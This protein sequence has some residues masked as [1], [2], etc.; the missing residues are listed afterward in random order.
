MA[1]KVRIKNIHKWAYEEDISKAFAEQLA[2][3]PAK[4]KIETYGPK[5]LEKGWA[6]FSTE[7]EAQKALQLNGYKIREQPLQ[8][9]IFQPEDNIANKSKNKSNDGNP[10][11]AEK[12]A[13]KNKPKNAKQQKK[14]PNTPTTAS[15]PPPSSTSTSSTPS[16]FT[17]SSIPSSTSP[18]HSPVPPS[19]SSSVSSTTNN[20]QTANQ[21]RAKK[22]AKGDAPGY[23]E[24]FERVQAKYK[25]FK[26]ESS[27]PVVASLLLPP[28]DPD[29]PFDLKGLQLQITIPPNYPSVPCIFKVMNPDS[30]VTE[31]LKKKIEAAVQKRAQVAYKD[32][33]ML[34]GLLFWL[35]RN[36]EQI[37]VDK[38]MTEDFNLA[39]MGIQLVVNATFKPPPR[40]LT[41]ETEQPIPPTPPVTTTSTEKS[42]EP[43]TA[44]HA[45][46]VEDKPTAPTP[47][48]TTALKGTRI[49][50]E[51]MALVNVGILECVLLN[52]TV[53]CE[54]CRSR[55]DAMNLI[56]GM[57]IT[58]VCEKCNHAYSV[59]FRPEIMHEYS[60]IV[61]YL[62]LEGCAIFDILPSSFKV[63]CF[64]CNGSALFKDMQYSDTKTEKNCMQ[65]HQ[66]ISI[67]L[68]R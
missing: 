64:E 18:N 22:G 16:S 50:F 5:S 39:K 4:V 7:E 56:K 43:A 57:Q 68:S 66:K 61:G 6:E 63:A 2:L 30:E 62:D 15:T 67:S 34:A 47:T 59:G 37:L 28:S 17:P 32:K 27:N 49:K 11:A 65:C 58:E 60:N 19:P 52:I 26:I 33:P 9:T 20:T 12:P 36:M 48:I 54:K 13:N 41:K 10:N 8:V 31:K 46:N 24:E 45:E 29:F 23:K 3:T 42:E 35:D 53:T 51:E 25:T 38:Q 40:E 44:E 1:F 14:P 55:I 21:P